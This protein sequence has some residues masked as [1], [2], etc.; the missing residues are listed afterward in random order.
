[1]CGLLTRAGEIGWR[2]RWGVRGVRR[3]CISVAWGVGEVEKGLRTGVLRMGSGRPKR[4]VV[5]L[6]D[7]R[8]REGGRKARRRMWKDLDGF[9]V[10]V[11]ER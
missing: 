6:A 9:I 8:G 10:F 3:T 1:M 7:W 4:L 2:A 5:G 11:E